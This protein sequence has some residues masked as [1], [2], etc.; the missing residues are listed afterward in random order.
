MKGL[1]RKLRS[2]FERVLHQYKP[3][4]VSTDVPADVQPF[5]FNQR[6][7][8]A[9]SAQAVS[10]KVVVCLFKNSCLLYSSVWPGICCLGL[11]VCCTYASSRR[12]LRWLCSV[13]WSVP[14]GPWSARILV[15]LC[16]VWRVTG[17]TPPYSSQTSSRFSRITDSKICNSKDKYNVHRK[18]RRESV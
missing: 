10:V 11:G 6:A 3:L 16:V 8:V 2:R 4:S 13:T 12:T 18:Y 7:A 1:T 17:F 15:L 9:F 14:R 5:L